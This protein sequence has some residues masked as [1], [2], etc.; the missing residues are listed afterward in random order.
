MFQNFAKTTRTIGIKAIQEI[1]KNIYIFKKRKPILRNYQDNSNW[2]IHQPTTN[3]YIC[4]Y[5]SIYT[6][7]YI[8]MYIYTFIICSTITEESPKKR[9]IFSIFTFLQFGEFLRFWLLTPLLQPLWHALVHP[10]GST[11][12]R[13]QRK[14]N[15]N[16]NQMES[17][18]FRYQYYSQTAQICPNQSKIEQNFHQPQI[19]IQYT[20]QQN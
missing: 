2:Y 5:I 18:N 6:H 3:M 9:D 4:I 10:Q 17:N 1:Y 7:I 16:T 20:M 13:R 8:Y 15:T 11:V 12:P 19:K 14:Q